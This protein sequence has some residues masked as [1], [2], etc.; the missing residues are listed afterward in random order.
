M[1]IYIR[2]REGKGCVCIY[3]RTRGGGE[4]VC[5]YVHA[6]HTVILPDHFKFASYGPGQL[7]PTK[8]TLAIACGL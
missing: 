2:T 8:D 4:G 1:C 7:L 6:L 3:I 5:V